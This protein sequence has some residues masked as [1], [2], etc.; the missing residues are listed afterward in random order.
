MYFDELNVGLKSSHKTKFGTELIEK[1]PSIPNTDKLQISTCDIQPISILHHPITTYKILLLKL[2]ETCP[3]K[4]YDDK[5]YGIPYIR[6][7]APTSFIGRQLPPT[8]HT[9]KYLISLENEEPI[10]AASAT[11]EYNRL[12]KSHATK[13]IIIQLS[14]RETS[15]TANYEELRSKFDQLQ[16]VIASNEVQHNIIYKI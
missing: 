13:V 5:T 12:R 1:Y 7:I 3:I 14:K 9:Q 10:Y 4:F 11:E 6:S 16:P 15:K 2:N 8:S